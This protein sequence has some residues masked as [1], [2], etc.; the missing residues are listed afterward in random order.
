MSE[1]NSISPDAQWFCPDI[2]FSQNFTEQGED[3]MVYS[4]TLVYLGLV[5]IMEYNR[6][7]PKKI[8]APFHNVPSDMFKTLP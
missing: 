5:I 1:Q 8:A 6:M 2:L 3:S 7:A 4:N